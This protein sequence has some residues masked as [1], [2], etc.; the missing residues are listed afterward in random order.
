MHANNMRGG[1]GGERE[2]ER[3][4]LCAGGGKGGAQLTCNASIRFCS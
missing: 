3:E 2:R 1:G 4:T